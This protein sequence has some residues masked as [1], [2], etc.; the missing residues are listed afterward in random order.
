MEIHNSV[1]FQEY[2]GKSSCLA[3]WEPQLRAWLA[4]APDLTL[5]EIC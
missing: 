4:V 3:D 1:L 5:A 2:L